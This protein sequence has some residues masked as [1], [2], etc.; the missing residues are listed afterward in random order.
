M[1][2][3]A[4][5][6]HFRED[7]GQILGG[8]VLR[9]VQA[10]ARH[11]EL[12]EVTKISGHTVLHPRAVGAEILVKTIENHR[13]NVAL[14]SQNDG[15]RVKNEAPEGPGGRKTA[16]YACLRSRSRRNCCSR[17]FLGHK[18]RNKKLFGSTKRGENR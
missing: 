10:D 8:D 5:E 16:R 14:G 11:T 7:L 4:V 6:R 15:K 9:G 3:R 2:F 13:K 12:H 18:S 17:R 1:V